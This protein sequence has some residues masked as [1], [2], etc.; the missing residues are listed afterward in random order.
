MFDRNSCK[1]DERNHDDCD[2]DRANNL[3]GCWDGWCDHAAR[4]GGFGRRA[5]PVCRSGVEVV[6][7]R[8]AR[9][10]LGSRLEHGSAWTRR[11]LGGPRLGDGAV[12]ARCSTVRGARRRGCG[13]LLAAGLLG[14]LLSAGRLGDGGGAAL[15]GLALCLFGFALCL[16]GLALCLFGFAAFAGFAQFALA[17]FLFACDAFAALRLGGVL[18]LTGG[19]AFTQ[20]LREGGSAV[21]GGRGGLVGSRRGGRRGDAVRSRWAE[22]PAPHA[23]VPRAAATRPRSAWWRVQMP[24]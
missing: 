19:C 5:R 10:L 7:A 12:Y 3:P 21:I 15:G 11:R 6:P 16:F 4:V 23:W 14:A 1:R 8:S 20:A 18:G 2:D 9:G 13:C 22:G 24:G 17:L